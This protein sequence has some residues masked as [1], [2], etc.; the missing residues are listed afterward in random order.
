MCIHFYRFTLRFWEI[1]G[2]VFNRTEAEQNSEKRRGEVG[3]CMR[4]G[5]EECLIRL[6]LNSEVR[7]D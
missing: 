4:E 5:D 3:R 7:L 1:G 2:C 6:A